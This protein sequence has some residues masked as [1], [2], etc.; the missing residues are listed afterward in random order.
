[1][2]DKRINEFDPPNL[3]LN[4]V[5]MKSMLENDERLKRQ[6]GERDNYWNNIITA[7][8]AFLGPA[9]T[10]ASLFVTLDVSAISGQLAGTIAVN[11]VLI[12]VI[13]GVLVWNLSR[14]LNADKVLKAGEYDEQMA[15]AKV[16]QEAK[17]TTKHTAVLLITLSTKGQPLKFLCRK[18]DSFLVHCRMDPK[19]TILE[20]ADKIKSYLTKAFGFERSDIFQVVPLEQEPFFTVKPVYHEMSSNAFVLYAVKLDQRVQSMVETPDYIW[21]SIEEMQNDPKAMRLNYDIIDK[22]DAKRGELTSSFQTQSSDLHIIWNITKACPY[23]C[24]ICATSD[25][26][27]EELPLEDKLKV[28]LTLCA[29]K[30]R[31]KTLDFAGG[32]PCFSGESRKLIQ[33]AVNM[34]GKEMISVTATAEGIKHASEEEKRQL[35]SRCEITIDASHENLSPPAADG[36]KRDEKQYSKSNADML[37]IFS[38]S[39]HKLSVNIP[40]LDGDLRA[41]E[42]ERLAEIILDIKNNHQSMAVEAHIIRLMPV[43]SYARN[44]TKEQYRQYHP[45]AVARSIKARLD[46]LGI[47]CTYHCSLRTLDALNEG[48]GRCSMLEHK[49]G[50]DCAGNVFACAWG[51]YLPGVEIMDNPFYL[52]NLTRESLEDILNDNAT[53]AYKRISNHIK[54]KRKMHYCEVVSRFF[55]KDSRENHD[56]LAQMGAEPAEGG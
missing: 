26:C 28:L 30:K 38:D 35:L 48:C 50:I 42:V 39:V 47:P 18:M 16:L 40:I 27:R 3:F 6:A 5:T 14:Y 13:I 17:D 21:R 10:L 23:R 29:E 31:I 52:G 36:T 8:L 41:D 51:A 4:R 22:L 20:Q 56:P 24:K 1:M 33:A 19:E 49:I 53:N 7:V 2:R 37:H 44:C 54:N 32:D 25:E 43:G 55:D 15:Y 45:I 46:S 9:T 11:A 12:A 34:L